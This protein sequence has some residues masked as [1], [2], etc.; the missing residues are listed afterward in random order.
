[1]TMTTERATERPTIRPTVHIQP[2]FSQAPTSTGPVRGGQLPASL[3]D[4]YGSD[5]TIPLRTDRPTVIANFVSTIDGVVSFK[6]PGEAGGG[7]VSG[8]FEPD[9]FV[10]GLLRSLA[11]AIVIGAGTLRDTRKHVWSPSHVHPPS[12]DAYR[13]VRE[14]LGLTVEPTTVVVTSNGGIDLTQRGLADP[15]V[16]VIVVTTNHGQ[17][18][19]E[20][21]AP[22]APNVDVVT[23]GAADHVESAALIEILR[24]RGF[25]LVLTEG[26][27]H[28]FGQL[29][30]AHLIDELFLT[31]APQIA[32]RSDEAP[33]LGLV[34]GTA[35][36]VA[37]APWSQ[38]VDLRRSGS[39]L[40][41][42]YRFQETA[43]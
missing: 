24:A 9:R 29:M 21:Q 13:L 14:Q 4:A 11:D 18:A 3:H 41:A 16:P 26:G 5:I 33:R 40:F 15:N 8:F 28:L 38:L 2:L 6:I 22:F 31:L 20:A 30:G 17:V 10:M 1:M 36:A 27:P 23:V 35:F 42:R 12:A 19:L 37:D 7:E 43:A 32:G 25:Q 34:E 39:N